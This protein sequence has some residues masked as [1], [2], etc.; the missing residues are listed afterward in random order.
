MIK[1]G[2]H[3]NVELVKAEK[4]DKGTLVISLKKGGGLSLAERLSSGSDESSAQ[5]EADF[6]I[7][8][9][10]MGEYVQT[11]QKVA[12]EFEALSRMLKHIL[13]GFITEDQIQKGFNPFNGIE[14]EGKTDIEI[15][16]M[17][18]TETV[19]AK[20]YSNIADQFIELVSPFIGKAM[21]F[22]VRLNRQSAKKAFSSFPKVGK[23]ANL[24]RDAFWESMD[25]KAEA[26]SVQYSNYE[27][28]F[29]KGDSIPD[30]KPSGTDLSNPDQVTTATAASAEET[31]AAEE[32]FG[33]AEA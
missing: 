10:T 1:V 31:K 12:E 6:I 21:L 19:L 15:T 29:R 2:I 14:L 20:M 13:K 26:S 11:G 9:I 8:P 23:F 17:L 32:M 4:N 24:D 3:E 5:E 16:E 30:G 28:G 7:W 27:L 25:V 33:G 18:T 22:R